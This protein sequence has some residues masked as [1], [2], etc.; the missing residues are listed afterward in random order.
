MNDM[1]N[2]IKSSEYEFPTNNERILSNIPFLKLPTMMNKYYLKSNQHKMK[3]ELLILVGF[4]VILIGCSNN[5]SNSRYKDPILAFKDS[6]AK[7]EG[8]KAIGCIN[9]GISEQQ[10]KDSLNSFLLSIREYNKDGIS[11]WT[12]IGLF[13]LDKSKVGT[14]FNNDSLVYVTFHEDFILNDDFSGSYLNSTIESLIDVFSKKYSSPDEYHPVSDEEWS[15]LPNNSYNTNIATWN[16]GRKRVHIEYVKV[17]LDSE[18]TNRNRI[19]IYLFFSDKITQQRIILEDH[20]Q[21]EKE[22]AISDSIQQKRNE[23]ISNIL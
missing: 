10:F 17:P 22:K 5:Q 18:T 14:Y 15:I 7:F 2:I 4:F 23:E 9:F 6:I 8:N 13:Y 3:A 19:T 11:Y 21:R 1:N 12:R 16:I 20:N